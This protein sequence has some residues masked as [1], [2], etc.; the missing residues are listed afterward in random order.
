MA[1]P[2]QRS[3]SPLYAMPFGRTRQAGLACTASDLTLMSRETTIGLD[4]IPESQF[5]QELV[6]SGVPMCVAPQPRPLTS[7]QCKLEESDVPNPSPHAAQNRRQSTTAQQQTAG[8]CGEMTGKWLVV[9]HPTI[10]HAEF[11]GSGVYGVDIY[12]QF[13]I[14][15]RLIG[16]LECQ[17]N[18]Q[19]AVTQREYDYNLTFTIRHWIGTMVMPARAAKILRLIKLARLIGKG[20]KLAKMLWDDKDVIEYVLKQLGPAIKVL[21]D[22]AD[23]ICKGKF[24]PKQLRDALPKYLPEGAMVA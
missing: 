2:K 14:E 7:L 23:L 12:Y 9:P 21:E 18:C 4:S 19:R 16:S 1:N 11:Q 6:D 15:G 22:S 17:D 20:A 8:D 3:T 5:A 13:H 10:D 24:D